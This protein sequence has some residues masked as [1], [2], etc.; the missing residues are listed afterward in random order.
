MHKSYAWNGVIQQQLDELVDIHEYVDFTWEGMVIY[1]VRR[2]PMDQP[3]KSECAATERSS[4][5]L[6]EC[7]GERSGIA[8]AP[9]AP[10]SLCPDEPEK[11]RKPEISELFT[12]TYPPKCK[13]GLLLSMEDLDNGGGWLPENSA[14]DWQVLDTENRDTVVYSAKLHLSIKVAYLEL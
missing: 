8:A 6:S 7:D 10:K 12:V 5:C 1:D 4:D 3:T 9:R 11:E 14:R 2:S 13:K